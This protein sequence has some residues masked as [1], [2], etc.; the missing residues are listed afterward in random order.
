MEK[1][2]YQDLE[3]E[4]KALKQKI[5]DLQIENERMK[6]ILVDNELQDEI[7]D[8]DCR[9]VE[10]R[11]CVNGINHIAAKVE[12]QDY[13]DRDIK[14]FEVLF[15]TLQSI[16]GI[17]PSKKKQKPADVKKLLKIVAEGK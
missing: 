5:T 10:E 8:V 1:D 6:K 2:L 9:S 4:L 16:R 12:A 3:L 11:L 13:S 7:E 17:E 14:S 15:R